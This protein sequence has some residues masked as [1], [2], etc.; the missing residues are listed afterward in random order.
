M[1]ELSIHQCIMTENDCFKAGKR[2]TPL[3]IVVHSTGANNPNLCRY[4]GPDDGVIG[5]NKYDNHWNRP[6]VKKC[7]HAFIGKLPDG[8][9]AI[10]QTL[11]WDCRAW[12]VGNG[13]RGTY[14]DTH[15][16]FE[17]CEDDRSDVF[18]YSEAF[19][20]AARLCA[21]L[22]LLYDLDAESVV[23]HYEAHAAGYANNHADPEPWQKKH[24][25]SMALFRKRVAELIDQGVVERPQT[26][27]L[28]ISLNTARELRQALNQ[29]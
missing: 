10:C 21:H 27:T 4:V 26:V 16:Q 5:Q 1:N 28:R 24:D 22:C 11:P 20:L 13:K 3:G 14:N 18:Y 15:I 2:I 6:N 8:R 25:D 9:A 19:D 7:V 29:E 12:G 17:I 23:G